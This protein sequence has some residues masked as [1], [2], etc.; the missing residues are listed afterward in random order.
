MKA[1]DVGR[2]REREKNVPNRA[3]GW[4]VGGG[5]GEWGAR[6]CRPEGPAEELHRAQ[7]SQ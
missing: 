4:A 3:G 7:G 2:E 6:L 1:R 5:G